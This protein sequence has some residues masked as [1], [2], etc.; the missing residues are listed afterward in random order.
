M[1]AC[2][3]PKVTAQLPP[4]SGKDSTQA[5]VS[6]T[7]YKRIAEERLGRRCTCFPN[8]D[9][10]MALCKKIG[11]PNKAAMVNA[12]HFLVIQ[13]NINA[14]V[15]EER[16]V[17]AEVEWFNATQLKITTI[18]GT[19]QALPNPQENYYLYDLGNKQ[20]LAPPN[21]KF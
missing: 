5:N 8:Q 18:S 7:D 14:V 2:K 21:S 4:M 6:P 1:G 9:H 19:V 13:I 3:S 15:Y 12:L 11:D 16:L 20:K 10:T 17:N